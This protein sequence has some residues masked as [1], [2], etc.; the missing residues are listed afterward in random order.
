MHHQR[1]CAS[2]LAVIPQTLSLPP[3]TRFKKGRGQ[4][5]EKERSFTS[6]TMLHTHTH[7]ITHHLSHSIFHHTI[8]HPHLCHTQSST[9]HLSDTI[10][11][12]TIFHPHL[13]HTLSFAALCVAAV[14]LGD[15]H[16]RFAWRLAGCVLGVALGDIYT[17]FFMWQVWH[18]ATSTFVLRGRRG[19]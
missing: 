8:L 1:M 16:L 15:I 5:E 3:A 14:A 17:F 9:H 19:T 6:I 10:F 7:P 4:K 2:S 13:C 11:H 18:L 12:H